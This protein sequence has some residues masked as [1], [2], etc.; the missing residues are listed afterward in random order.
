MK[1]IALS[2]LLLIVGIAIKAQSPQSLNM[3][4]NK[5]AGNWTT[6]SGSTYSIVDG[7]L[8]C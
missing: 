5:D 3:S 4:F 1:K 7:M 6:E 8:R 2:I